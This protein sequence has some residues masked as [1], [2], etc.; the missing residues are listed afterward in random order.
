MDD[1][2]WIC[3]LPSANT[4]DLLLSTPYLNLANFLKTFI[5]KMMTESMK[6]NFM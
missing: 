5:F 6:L 4:T 3:F 1:A 2:S